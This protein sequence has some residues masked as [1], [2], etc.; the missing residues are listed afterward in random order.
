MHLATWIQDVCVKSV[1]RLAGRD[2]DLNALHG[3]EVDEAEDDVQAL[4]ITI[5]QKV[6]KIYEQFCFDVIESS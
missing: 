4:E 5:N 2:V 1:V 6:S 3:G